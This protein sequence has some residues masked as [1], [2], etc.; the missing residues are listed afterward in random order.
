MQEAFPPTTGAALIALRKSLAVS[1]IDIANEL[2][3]SRSTVFRWE[4]APE[5]R[6]FT[7]ARYEGACR[8]L[9]ERARLGEPA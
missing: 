3:V 9:I 7:F 1:P 5:V 6:A 4:K 8:R 2:Q